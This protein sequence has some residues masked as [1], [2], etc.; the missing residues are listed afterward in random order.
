MTYNTPDDPRVPLDSAGRPL[1]RTVDPHAGPIS[2]EED[3]WSRDA[4]AAR[5][6]WLDDPASDPYVDDPYA[7]G[8]DLGLGPEDDP[9]RFYPG[10]LDEDD[11]DDGGYV[12][13]AMDTVRRNPVGSAMIIA[14]LALL[15]APRVERDTVRAQTQ[16]LQE[17]VRG[18][19]AGTESRTRGQFAQQ[20]DK[21][22]GRTQELRKR[23]TEGTEDMSEEARKRVIAARR[24]ALD[25]SEQAREGLRSGA[26]GTNRMIRDNPLA[27]GALAVA[28]GAA[29]AA[30]IPGSRMENRRL[31]PMA[32]RFWDE[33]RAV[34]EE[35]RARVVAGANAAMDEAR[36]VAT[37]AVRDVKDAVPDGEEVV[38]RTRDQAR[39]A[40]KRVSEA[41]R[42]GAKAEGSKSEGSGSG[43]S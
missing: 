22:S 1:K 36:S 37:E 43:K 30:A 35:E 26:S 32:H 13:T 17:R 42:D 34:F 14:G 28:A 12:S 29:I 20:R 21:L 24:R 39:E 33:A 38:D 9:D 19:Y 6:P 3:M 23:I 11:D 16:R 25:M 2:A 8:D 15:A 4:A 10:Y 27:A 5:D 18:R 41:A 31:G 7:Y 40:A